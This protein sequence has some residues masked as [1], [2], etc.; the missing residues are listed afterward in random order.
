VQLADVAFYPEQPRQR[1]GE[2]GVELMLP[3]TFQILRYDGEG[4]LHGATLRSESQLQLN[5]GDDSRVDAL[6]S[7]SGRPGGGFAGGE[8]EL[9]GDALVKAF[10]TT[11][12]GI[13]MVTALELGE[14]EEKDPGRPSLILRPLGDDDLWGVAKRCG[15]TVDA[16]M[17]ANQLTDEPERDRMLLIP[18]S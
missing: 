15:S 6:C 11:A 16:I 5:A 17:R 14:L 9:R 2:D 4:N 1:R 10:T 12:C 7:P 3:C 13:P 18:V 8:V